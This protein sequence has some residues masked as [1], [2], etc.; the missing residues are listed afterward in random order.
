MTTVRISERQPSQ[1]TNVLVELPAYY[2]H[3]SPHASVSFY[4]ETDGAGDLYYE[5]VVQGQ[6]GMNVSFH[7]ERIPASDLVPD[8]QRRP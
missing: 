3:G 8:D 2:R 5:V 4:V 7:Y 1:Q 6:N